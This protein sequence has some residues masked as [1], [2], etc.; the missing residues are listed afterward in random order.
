MNRFLG[1]ESK[2]YAVLSL[3]ADLVIVNVLVVITCFPVVTGGMSLRT[4]H[5]VTGHMV[6]EEGSRRGSAFIRNLLTRPW[7]NTA[8]WLICLAAVGLAAYEFAIIA[9]ADLG[10]MGIVLRAALISGLIVLSCI[11]VWF[12][13]LDAPSSGFRRRCAAAITHAVAH[14][15]RTLLAIAPGVLMVLFPFF[16]PEQW[17][18]Y[19]FFLAVFGPALA[20]YL[21]ELA[22]QWPELSTQ[23]ARDS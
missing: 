13:H 7:T 16:F 18:S 2:F 1:P 9:R 8:W 17:G 12:F 19:V 14:L 15:P 4:A 21:A 22:L 3:F 10:H 23:A 6:R 5:E 11:S 20:I